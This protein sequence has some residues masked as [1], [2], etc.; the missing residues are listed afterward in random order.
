M[1]HIDVVYNSREDEWNVVCEGE[2]LLASY[3]SNDIYRV[4]DILTGDVS[5]RKMAAIIFAYELYSRIVENN[6]V[7]F[8]SKYMLTKLFDGAKIKSGVEGI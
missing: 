5:E 7:D 8:V 1:K 2:Y 3:D 6:D 4:Y